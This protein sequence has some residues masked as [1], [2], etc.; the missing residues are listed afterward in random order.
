M[1]VFTGGYGK[2]GVPKRG[3]LKAAQVAHFSGQKITAWI[4]RRVQVL[5][6]M[7]YS[8][9]EKETLHGRS[10]GKS[11]PVNE[12]IVILMND[13]EFPRMTIP[14]KAVI[15]GSKRTYRC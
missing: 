6:D 11:G 12:S 3:A 2:L 9:C 13:Q 7:G 4:V 15:E 10:G 8:D 5:D 14:V 1:N